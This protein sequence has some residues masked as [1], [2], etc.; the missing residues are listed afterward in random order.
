M[1]LHSLYLTD[2]VPTSDLDSKPVGC[3]RGLGRLPMLQV[4]SHAEKQHDL[5]HDLHAWT[6][7]AAKLA[8]MRRLAGTCC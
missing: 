7:V 8:V 5:Q 6:S 4:V 2:H 3:N 1:H